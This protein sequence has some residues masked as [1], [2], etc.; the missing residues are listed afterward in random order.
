[1]TEKLPPNLRWMQQAETRWEHLAA[2]AEKDRKVLA[3]YMEIARE[4]QAAIGLPELSEDEKDSIWAEANLAAMHELRVGGEISLE[5]APLYCRYA[6]IFY[7]AACA[8][9]R[10]QK[11]DRA[12]RARLI[13][14]RLQ[15][16]WFGP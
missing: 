13:Q 15:F 4:S 11:A 8:V 12:T 9:A 1:M 10:E 14:R 3:T 5:L 6:I 7:D 2:G 16:R